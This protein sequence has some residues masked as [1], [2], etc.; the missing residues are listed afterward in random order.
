MDVL[1][2]SNYDDKIAWY[3]NTDGQGTFSAQKTI[4]TQTDGAWSVYAADIDGDGDVDVLSAASFDDK[5]AWYENTDG[6]GTFVK[7]H[8]ANGAWSVYAADLDGD[9]DIDV[10]SASASDKK[11]AWYENTDIEDI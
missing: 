4:T 9:G 3:E 10:L 6:Q 7:T 2:A 11:I 1:S 8:Q 5:V